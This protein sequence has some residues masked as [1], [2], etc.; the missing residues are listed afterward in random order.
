MILFIFHCSCATSSERE[1]ARGVPKLGSPQ[2]RERDD[3]G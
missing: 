3:G 2:E 1:R